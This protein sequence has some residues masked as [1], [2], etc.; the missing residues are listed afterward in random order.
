MLYQLPNGKTIHLTIDEY[1]NL[2][3]ED[4]QFFMA[5]DLGEHI[6]Y[7][8]GFKTPAEKEYNFED[9]VSDEEDTEDISYNNIHPDDQLDM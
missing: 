2:S 4:I 9:Y 7:H 6:P 3:D 1:L 5:Y 8:T